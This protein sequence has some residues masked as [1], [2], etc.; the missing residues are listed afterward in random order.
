M[1]LQPHFASQRHQHPHFSQL[2]VALAVFRTISVAH[3]AILLGVPLFLNLAAL[4]DEE[5]HLLYGDER[6]LALLPGVSRARLNRRP[7]PGPARPEALE[8]VPLGER[9]WGATPEQTRKLT[10]LST[11]LLASGAVDPGGVAWA[12]AHSGD[13]LRPYLLAPDTALVLRWNEAGGHSTEVVL[14]ALSWLRDQASGFGGVLTTS[15]SQATVPAPSEEVDVHHHPGLPAAELL[16]LHAGH[17]LRHG[18]AQKLSPE[19]PWSVPWQRLYAL[20]LMAWERRGL[21]ISPPAGRP[22]P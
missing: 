17:V 18:R 7:E 14:E 11:V 16:A 19:T 1:A 22:E 20:N 5:L 21:L 15:R 10:A 9:L 8:V 13:H 2:A 4:S 6:T 3:G 12:E